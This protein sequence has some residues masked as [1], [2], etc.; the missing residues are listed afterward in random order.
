MGQVLDDLQWWKEKNTGAEARAPQ[1]ECYNF[2]L[3]ERVVFQFHPRSNMA[4]V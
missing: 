4:A 2:Q 3:L 1:P